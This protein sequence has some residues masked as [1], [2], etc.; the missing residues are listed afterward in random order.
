MVSVAGA[1]T[2]LCRCRICGS[3]SIGDPIAARE[4]MF[5]TREAFTYWPCRD[6]GTLQIGEFPHDMTRYYPTRSYYSFGNTRR[7]SPLRRAVLRFIAARVIGRGIPAS[8]S[9]GLA[10]QLKGL[11]QPWIASVPGLRLDTAILDVG[12]GEGAE[13]ES[14]AMLGFTRLTGCDPYMPE[15]RAGMTK[16]GVKLL[17]CQLA[18]VEGRFDLITMHHSLEHF[19]DPGGMLELAR[20]KLAEGGRIMVSVPVMQAWCW[21]RFG[22]NWAQFDAPRHFYLFTH[23]ALVGLAERGGLRCTAHGYNSLGWVLAWSEMYARDIPM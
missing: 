3:S 5:G 20:G 16:W 18:E 11:G 2:A 21:E 22:A 17:R 19:T 1:Q 9:K 13:L 10:T 12:S 23:R 4:M 7:V 15:A 14:L 6:C 8:G